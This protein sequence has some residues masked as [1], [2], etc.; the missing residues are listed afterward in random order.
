[1]KQKVGTLKGPGEP[2]TDLD[3]AFVAF[4]N[5]LYEKI[6]AEPNKGIVISKGNPNQRKVRWT[7]VMLIAHMLEDF[8]I[9][10]KQRTGGDICEECEHWGSIS[11]ASPHIGVCKR[12]DVSYLHKFN[13]C[14]KFKRRSG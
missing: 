1:M 12:Y 6:E 14:K 8:F 9:L 5:L 13:S 7:D 10:R 11:K 2:I 3:V 4:Y